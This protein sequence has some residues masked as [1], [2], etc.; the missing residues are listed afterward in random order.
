MSTKHFLTTILIFAAVLFCYSSNAQD[1]TDTIHMVKRNTGRY[2]YYQNNIEL[3]KKQVMNL[4]NENNTAIKLMEK[5]N[6]LNIAAY[7]F[8]IPGG[9]CIGYS[10]GYL[11]TQ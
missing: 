6:N 4:L 3:S 7:C 1:R 2:L 5:S 8:A 11:L 10:F 9:F